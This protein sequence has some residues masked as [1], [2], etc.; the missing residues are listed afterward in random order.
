MCSVWCAYCH[1]VLTVCI[2]II[3][4]RPHYGN[5]VTSDNV[6]KWRRDIMWPQEILRPGTKH[7][8]LCALRQSGGV[9][10]C[11]FRNGTEHCISPHYQLWQSG[12]ATLCDHRRYCDQTLVTLN[13]TTKWWRYLMWP[14]EILHWR[15]LQSRWCDQQQNML[16][17]L[18]RTLRTPDTADT[19]REKARPPP[20][21][22]R[23]GYNCRTPH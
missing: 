1:M 8:R 19:S 2:A 5:A 16:W 21:C 20:R 18:V 22:C 3:L 7:W 23:A 9:S 6:T 13:I 11:V 17:W 12:G 10:L 14:Q 4:C 15:R